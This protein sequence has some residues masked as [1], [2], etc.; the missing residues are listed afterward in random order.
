V[1]QK[2]SF[3]F[4]DLLAELQQLVSV[5]EQNTD[6]LEDSLKSCQPSDN[7]TGACQKA[8]QDTSPPPHLIVTDNGT[9]TLELY[10]DE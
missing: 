8:L 10:T 4:E 7:F 9:P 2:Q 3:H 5:L 6:G 1:S